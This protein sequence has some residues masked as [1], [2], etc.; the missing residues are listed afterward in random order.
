MSIYEVYNDL[1]KKSKKKI[2]LD[3]DTFNEVDDQFALVYAML[4]TDN[5][6]LLSVNA[7]PFHNKKVESPKEGMEKS[8]EEI[9]RLLELMGEKIEVYKGSEQYLPDEKTP[10]PS[11]AAAYMA[12][13]AEEYTAENPLYIVAIGAITN[14]ASAMLL[15]PDMKNKVVVVWLGGHGRH[16]HNTKEF[17]MQ[18]DVAAARVV[19]GSGVPFVQLPCCGVVDRFTVSRPELEHWLVGKNPLADYLAVNTIKEAE[20]YARGAAWT[21]VIWD[22]TAVAWLLNDR[23]RFMLWRT[24][25]TA[26]PGYDHIYESDENGHPMTYVYYINRDALMTDL[27]HKLTDWG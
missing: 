20:S 10:V 25:R 16:F 7:A 19:M 12:R 8:Y 14:M 18:Q 4:S 3:T 11:D 13:I 21:R 15:N 6:E 27:F 17:N 5:V 1:K 2:I 24:E 9:L 22:V 23:N 26:L